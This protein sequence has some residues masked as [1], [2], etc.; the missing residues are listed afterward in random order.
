M[1]LHVHTIDV[2]EKHGA[3]AALQLS[4]SHDRNAISK[5]VSFVHKMCGQDQCASGSLTLKDV[6]RLSSRLWIHS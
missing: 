6:P 3:A 4:I 2:L 1:N 5:Q